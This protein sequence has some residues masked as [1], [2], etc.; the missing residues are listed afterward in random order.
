M[1]YAP[2][3]SVD[4]KRS[5]SMYK[6]ILSDNRISFTIANLAKYKGHNSFFL[7]K[8]TSFFIFFVIIML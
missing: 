7:N 5:F 2:I 3:T 1:N 6:N 4:V 8:Y